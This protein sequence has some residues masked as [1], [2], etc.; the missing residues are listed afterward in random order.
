MIILGV[1]RSILRVVSIPG[2]P[3]LLKSRV[4]EI[5]SLVWSQLDHYT[6]TV[7]HVSQSILGQILSLNKQYQ[8]EGKNRIDYFGC[9]SL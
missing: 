9:S 2:S 8:E 6:D 5:L 7:R 1:S 4:F 3:S